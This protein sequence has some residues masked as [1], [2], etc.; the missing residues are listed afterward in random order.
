MRLTAGAAIAALFFDGAANAIAVD[1]R[2]D[3]VGYGGHL[4]L[5]RAIV[6]GKTTSVTA[7]VNLGVG[8]SGPS[9]V[10]NG[11]ASG[12]LFGGASRAVLSITEIKG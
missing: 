3:A 5:R 11:N 7:Q 12:R 10:V 6:A 2:Y 8:S 9:A 4:H 1:H